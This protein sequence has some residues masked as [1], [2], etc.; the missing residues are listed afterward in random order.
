MLGEPARPRLAFGMVGDSLV[1]LVESGAMTNAPRASTP[2]SASPAC[3]SAPTT[4]S[5]AGRTAT[6][7]SALPGRRD[8]R[9]RGAVAAAAFRL[10]Q[11]GARGR[12]DRPGQRRERR[13]RLHRRRRRPGRLRARRPA[14]RP[15][16][17]RSSPCRAPPRRGTLPR[18]VARLSRPGDDAAQRRR[19]RR[20]RTRRGAAARHGA[21]GAGPGDDRAG[22]A[23]HRERSRARHA[24][25][26]AP[27]RC[28]SVACGAPLGAS[29]GP[30]GCP[31]WDAPGGHAPETLGLVQA[32]SLATQGH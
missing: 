1:D 25:T 32:G 22:R 16:A 12:S 3:C 19:H 13:R 18:I 10:D 4:G 29:P 9:R 26:S 7:R 2:A 6:R 28:A 11:L 21:A 5:T 23:E 15:A 8:A 17:R 24:S 27:E 20:D 30:A 31:R 14:T